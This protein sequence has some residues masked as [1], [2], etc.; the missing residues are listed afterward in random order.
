[1]NS[2]LQDFKAELFRA[3]ANPVRIRIL[4]ALR[5]EGS[6][7]VGEIQQRVGAEHS[8][9]SQHLS[10]MRGRGLVEAQREGTTI[11]YSVPEPDLYRLL[12]AARAIFEHQLDARARALEESDRAELFR[13][14]S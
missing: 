11:R 5:A 4:E 3:L 13:S 10:I 8:N 12:D 2:T 6:L 9:V 7:N 1:M 14:R